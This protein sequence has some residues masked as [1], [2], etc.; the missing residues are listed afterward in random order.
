M[1]NVSPPAP[2]VSTILLTAARE[3]FVLKLSQSSESQQEAVTDVSIPSINID[4]VCTN[5]NQS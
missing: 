2:G 5:Q 4:L 3:L 1:T